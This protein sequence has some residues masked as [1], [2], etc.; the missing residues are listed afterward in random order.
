MEERI[1]VEND[2][3]V[4]RQSKRGGTYGEV[5]LAV[6]VS[7]PLSTRESQSFAFIGFP[8]VPTA[9]GEPLFYCHDTM[10]FH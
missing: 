9:F 2:V 7:K 3:L 8:L 6:G 10:I 4:N 5:F 1:I